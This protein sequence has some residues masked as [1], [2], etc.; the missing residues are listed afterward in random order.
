MKLVQ[1]GKLGYQSPQIEVLSVL[2]D[3]IMVS[4]EAEGFDVEKDT[5]EW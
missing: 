5:I 2:E 4:L 1:N 3:V